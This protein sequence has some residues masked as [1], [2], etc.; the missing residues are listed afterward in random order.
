M[1]QV[2]NDNAQ[3]FMEA[4][5]G[6]NFILL[7]VR[8]IGEVSKGKIANSI[9]IDWF[10]DNFAT[11]VAKLDKKKTI[12]VYCASGGRSEEAAQLLIEHGFLAV[13]NL[14]DGLKAWKEAGFPIVV[15]K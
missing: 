2:I 14:K 13:H 5:N 7:D 4:M 8:T 6:G 15:P 10:D 11:E 3:Q 9:H 12:L 1:M